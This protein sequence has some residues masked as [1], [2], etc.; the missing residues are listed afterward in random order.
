MLFEYYLTNDP[1]VGFLWSVLGWFSCLFQS[2]AASVLLIIPYQLVTFK[3][4][5]NLAAAEQT[6]LHSC[7][8]GVCWPCHQFAHPAALLF[9]MDSL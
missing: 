2:R 3:L 8:L 5:G 7:V 1:L 9:S 4:R 6:S